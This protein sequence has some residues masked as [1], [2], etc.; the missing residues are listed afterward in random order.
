MA[1]QGVAAEKTDPLAR[2][3]ATRIKP[4]WRKLPLSAVIAELRDAA[5]V[6]LE[7][8][9]R[10]PHQSVTLSASTAQDADTLL[11]TLL[12]RT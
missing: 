10:H 9:V 4:S 12:G 2:L 6:L 1:S 5:G 8:D 7:L 3:R 11:R